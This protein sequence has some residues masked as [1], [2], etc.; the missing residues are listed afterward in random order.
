MTSLFHKSEAKSFL[1]NNFQVRGKKIFLSI[2]ILLLSLFLFSA[3][4]AQENTDEDDPIKIFNEG[5]S[6]HEKGEYETA[7]KF[8]DKALE[9]VPEFPEAE[10]QRGNALLSLKKPD[11][12]E[13]AFRRAIELRENWTLPMTSL[14]VLLIQKNEFDEA[15]KILTKTIQLS[16]INFL[17]Y[18]A[19]TDLK[20]KTKAAPEELKQLLTKIQYLTT[21]A[22]PTASLWAS[23]AALERALG[24]KKSAK[25]SLNRAIELD[26]FDKLALAERAEISIGE[27]DYQSASEDANKLKQMSTDSAN[28]SFLLA[29]IQAGK[30]DLEESAKILAAIKNPTTEML[31]FRDKIKANSSQNVEELEKLLETDE[32]NAAVLGRLC[33]LLRAENPEKALDYCR[34]ASESEPDNINHAIGYGAALVTAKKYPNAIELFKRLLEISPDNY[35]I[36]ANYATALFQSKRFEEAK[37][38]YIWI[39]QK[40]P[41]LAIT[42]YLLGITHDSLEEYLDAVAN[43]QQFLRIADETQN[44]LEIEKVNL[45]LPG[46]QRLIKQ[47]KGKKN[48]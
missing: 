21:K 17:A 11:E 25:Y 39:T 31:M 42:Y 24:D 7:L 23:R 16:G 45:R 18:S 6:A 22:S 33:N 9:I 28:V 19:L 15:D 38:E 41:D 32:K 13:K 36:H 47:G 14:G 35:T 26:P 29:R 4:F 46:L 27:G 3:T 8:Y 34:R 10:Y 5:Q 48:E 44:K 37:A 43:Y 2:S 12:A 1:P 40:Q 30:G 20:L